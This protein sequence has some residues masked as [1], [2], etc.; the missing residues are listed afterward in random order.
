MRITR[1][2]LQLAIWNLIWRMV[3][4]RLT[5]AIPKGV[6]TTIKVFVNAI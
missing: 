3:K 4:K 2:I 6:L 1:E 5:T